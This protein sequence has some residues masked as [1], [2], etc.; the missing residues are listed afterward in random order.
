MNTETIFGIPF[1]VICLAAVA[2]PVAYQRLKY[3][4]LPSSFAEFSLI[5]RAT[6]LNIHHAHWGLLFILSTGVWNSL[7]ARNEWTTLIFFLGLGL[8]LD[9]I[10]PHLRMPGTDRALELTIYEKAARPSIILVAIVIIAIV[11]L[12][13][14]AR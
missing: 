14:V 12:F 10:I 6:G 1:I 3:L 5:R 11:A 9:E 4:L 7:F 8:L 13:Y 2:L